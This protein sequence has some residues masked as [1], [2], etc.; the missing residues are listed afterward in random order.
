M[1][2]NTSALL[3]VQNAAIAALFATHPHP[4]A[5]SSAFTFH[6]AETCGTLPEHSQLRGQIQVWARTFRIH[7]PAKPSGDPPA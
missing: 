2:T 5:L 1:D 4:E 7:I 6:L 3:H